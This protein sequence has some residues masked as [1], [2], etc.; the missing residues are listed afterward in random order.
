MAQVQSRPGRRDGPTSGKPSGVAGRRPAQGCRASRPAPLATPPN[1]ARVWATS[2]CARSR[3]MVG[4]P[5]QIRHAGHAQRIADARVDDLVG[6][7][8]HADMRR[9]R[10]IGDRHRDAVALERPQHRPHAE[11]TQQRHAADAARNDHRVR[12]HLVIGGPTPTTWTPDV[13]NPVTRVPNRIDTLPFLATDGPARGRSDDNRPLLRSACRWRRR[14]RPGCRP[15][16]A[17]RH[18]GV[19]VQR[20]LLAAQAGPVVQQPAG[21]CVGRLPLR[22]TTSLPR[23]A[24]SSRRPRRVLRAFHEGL[25]Q[26]PRVESQPQQLARGRLAG[27]GVARPAR[28][29]AASATGRGRRS[30]GSAS[31]NRG[32]AASPAPSTARPARPAAP[33]SCSSAARRWQSWSPRPALVAL[34]YGDLVAILGQPPCSG[35]A[36]HPCSHN[37]YAHRTC[38]AIHIESMG[39]S[40]VHR[41]RLAQC[42]YVPE[43]VPRLWMPATRATRSARPSWPVSAAPFR[44]IS[45]TTTMRLRQIEVFRAVMLTGTV[46]EAARLLHVSQPW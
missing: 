16:R 44:T 46:S 12:A 17:Q 28:R 43:Y 37:R 18:R 42:Q 29:P 22:C 33:H 26:V 11:R 6:E 2:V 23:R 1:T 31:A 20:L 10:A 25:H 45:S 13:I 7:V 41:A 27:G 4:P 30:D 34:Q 19:A 21:R 9:P 8:R 32:P 36:D 5:H 35:H 15:A 24:K 39:Q 3:S 14:C 38:L 40:V